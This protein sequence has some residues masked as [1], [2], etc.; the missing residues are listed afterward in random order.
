MYVLD[1]WKVVSKGMGPDSCRRHKKINGGNTDVLA[2][3]LEDGGTR[4]TDLTG[5]G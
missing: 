4:K 2:S 3:R 1:W 5:E